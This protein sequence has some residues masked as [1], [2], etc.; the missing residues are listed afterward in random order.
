MNHQVQVFEISADAKPGDRP[1]PLEGFA[2]TTESL[3]GARSAALLRLQ[4]EGRAVRSLSFTA[5][6][7]LAAVVFPSPPVPT[8]SSVPRRSRGGR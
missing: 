3:E 4:G 1:R 6:G 5:G 2:V 7:G 8:P